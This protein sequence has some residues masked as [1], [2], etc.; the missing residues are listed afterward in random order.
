MREWIGL[1]DEILHCSNG[2]ME[3]ALPRY[4]DTNGGDP[5]LFGEIL[6]VL[7]SGSQIIYALLLQ[8]CTGRPC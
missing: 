7:S 2:C 1:R 4:C 3:G 5:Q 6:T 8:C